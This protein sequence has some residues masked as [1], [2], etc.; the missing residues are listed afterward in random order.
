M[1]RSFVQS[2]HAMAMAMAP[3]APSIARMDLPAAASATSLESSW[4]HSFG[5]V[6]VQNGALKHFE[7]IK[8]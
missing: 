7:T 8:F 4:D 6:S 1:V 2:C 3:M 5:A